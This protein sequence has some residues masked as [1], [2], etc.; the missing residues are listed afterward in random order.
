[1]MDKQGVIGTGKQIME[2]CSPLKGEETLSNS[3]GVHHNPNIWD[4]EAGG[5]FQTSQ[6]C[7]VSMK[8]AWI[9]QRPCPERKVQK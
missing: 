5:K 7:I 4:P 8:S 3:G 2:Y 9:T 1:M 6:G